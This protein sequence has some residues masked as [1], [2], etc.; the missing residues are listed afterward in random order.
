MPH[1]HI[2]A[3][4]TYWVCGRV[5][6]P[7]NQ[8]ISTYNL[9]YT[10]HTF[11]CTCPN[12]VISQSSNKVNNNNN[13]WSKSNSWSNVNSIL[14]ILPE[15]QQQQVASNGLAFFWSFRAARL[16][17]KARVQC[18]LCL[19]SLCHFWDKQI[20]NK[21]FKLVRNSWRAASQPK[22]PKVQ[23]ER[24]KQLWEWTNK[25]TLLSTTSADVK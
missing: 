17:F 15:Q 8:S 16:K 24:A 1:C 5:S 14:V 12:C 23:F 2:V 3:R 25:Q 10:A 18:L 13:N 9:T 19:F 4:C 22:W 6:P 20:A 21:S 7:T 11:R